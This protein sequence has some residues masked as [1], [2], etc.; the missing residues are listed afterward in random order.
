[1]NLCANI[2]NVDNF[3]D[4]LGYFFVGARAAAL[5]TSISNGILSARRGKRH[6]RPVEQVFHDKRHARRKL[7]VLEQRAWSSAGR[8]SQDAEGLQTMRTLGDNMAWVL[9]SLKTADS[10]YP[11]GNRAS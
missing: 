6:V 3:W 7:P 11:K 2:E 1:M 9:K 4:G 10:R 5:S 8:S